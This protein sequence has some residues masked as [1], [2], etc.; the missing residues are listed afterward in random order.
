MLR[1]PL[2]I[3]MEKLLSYF[4]TEKS[5]RMSTAVRFLTFLS[6]LIWASTKI[7]NIIY[8][9]CIYFL[10]LSIDVSLHFLWQSFDIFN[11]F[12]Y[13]VVSWEL[14][15]FVY[16]ELVNLW[17]QSFE[18]KTCFQTSSSLQQ[19]NIAYMDHLNCH[20]I[21]LREGKSLIIHTTLWGCKFQILLPVI[22][23]IKAE[24]SWVIV[25]TVS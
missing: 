6:W 24:T 20:E 16:I 13:M 9:K 8:W 21:S 22:V 17:E 12:L 7:L 4:Y 15:I 18:E 25:T 11:F 10:I 14:S 19:D 3:L 23:S 5:V 1:L 2:P